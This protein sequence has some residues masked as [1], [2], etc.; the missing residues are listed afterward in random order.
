MSVAFSVVARLHHNLLLAFSPSYR[1]VRK[2]LEAI[3]R[4]AA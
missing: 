2:R 3:G 1:Q 4:Q